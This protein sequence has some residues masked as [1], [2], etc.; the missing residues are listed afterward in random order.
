MAGVSRFRAE[1]ARRQGRGKAKD[2]RSRRWIFASYDQLTDRVGPL[3]DDDPRNLG[4][5]LVEHPAKAMRRPYHRQK[6]A[7]VLACGRQFALEQAERGVRVEHMVARSSLAETLIEFSMRMGAPLLSMEAAER[8]QRR[9]LAPAIAAG[10][11]TIV[12]NATWLTDR[13]DFAKAAPKGPPWR[14]D[15]FYRQVRRRTGYL[16]EDGRPLGGKWSFDAENRKAWRGDPPAPAPP[17]FRPDPVTQEVLELVAEHYGEHPGELNGSHLP[18]TAADAERLWKHAREAC[19]PH[20]GPFEDAM[21]RRSDSLFHTR[22]SPLLNLGRLLPRQV[23]EDTLALD[24]PLASKEGFVRQV[25]G[26]REFMAHVHRETEGLTRLPGGREPF[27]LGQGAHLPPAYWGTASGLACLD[28]V[29]ANVWRTGYSHHIE[30]LMV[31]SNLA[32]LLDLSPR[33][34]TDWF[35]VAYTDAY[36]W[37]VEPNVLGMGT[38]ALGDLFTTKPYVSGAAYLARMS[39]DCGACA[40]DPKSDCPITGLYW[41]FLARHR[42]T[43]GNQPRMA[44]PLRSLAKRSPALRAKDTH[45]FERVRAALAR[46]ERLT[47]GDLG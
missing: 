34:L 45:T 2:E 29:V 16:M 10:A 9:D 22:I 26:W 20:F 33:E 24:L 5:L 1:L 7:L 41:A 3:A 35:W 15:A 21:S 40:F 27:V 30:R 28:R 6:L 38:F 18:A 25:L 17:S 4:L 32:T 47:P 42:E 8:E 13:E 37:V 11:L 12:P 14:M 31:L 19:L 46:G 39:D 36:D 23:V 44:M 43:L